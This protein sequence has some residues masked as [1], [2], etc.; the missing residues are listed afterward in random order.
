METG[1]LNYLQVDIYHVYT[2]DFIHSEKSRNLIA[3]VFSEEKAMKM[4]KKHAK[5]K[6]YKV[7][8]ED[9]YSLRNLFQT[10]DHDGM[11]EYLLERVSTNQLL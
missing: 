3:I 10:Q 8:R 6:G 5:S 7:S 1:L 4:I 9:K 11:V 2:T